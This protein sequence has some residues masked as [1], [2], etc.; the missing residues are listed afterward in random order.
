MSKRFVAVDDESLK[1]A[2]E[3]AGP[4][5]EVTIAYQAP[6]PVLVFKMLVKDLPGDLDEIAVDEWMARCSEPFS[7]GRISFAHTA[8]DT[9]NA[10]HHGP[11]IRAYDQDGSQKSPD[12]FA[13]FDD[14]RAFSERDM[15]KPTPA[16]LE[17]VKG[18]S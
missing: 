9:S 13:A 17:I 5:D 4:E 11:V 14:A 2:L 3:Q 18:R 12:K 10:D 8:G 1:E 15:Y 16:A 7:E 6:N